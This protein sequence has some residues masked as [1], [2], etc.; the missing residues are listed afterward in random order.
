MKPFQLASNLLRLQPNVRS[1]LRRNTCLL[2]K[3]I[4]GHEP[5]ISKHNRQVLMDFTENESQHFSLALYLLLSR[6]D[7]EQI[8]DYLDGLKHLI[9]DSH[10]LKHEP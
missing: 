5:D 3:D 7:E 1:L 9:I 4:C 8:C 2:L 6:F 10:H